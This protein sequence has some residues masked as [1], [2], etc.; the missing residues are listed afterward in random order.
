[1]F[2]TKTP[3]LSKPQNELANH[4][5][6]KK[7]HNNIKKVMVEGG[8]RAFSPRDRIFLGAVT[9]HPFGRFVDPNLPKVEI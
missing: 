2:L 6:V 8:K 5:S 4:E 3:Y 1:M 7:S 9:T